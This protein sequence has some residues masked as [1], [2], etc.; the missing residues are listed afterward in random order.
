MHTYSLKGCAR[1]LSYLLRAVPTPAMLI[2]LQQ[3]CI[4][5]QIQNKIDVGRREFG[6]KQ[7]D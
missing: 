2:F 7:G 5:G 3:T 4:L 6:A 1:N